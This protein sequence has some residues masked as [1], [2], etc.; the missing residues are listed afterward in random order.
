MVFFNGGTSSLEKR[1]GRD[2]Y[3]PLP[4]GGGYSRLKGGGISAPG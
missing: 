1:R 2:I 4:L 3:T